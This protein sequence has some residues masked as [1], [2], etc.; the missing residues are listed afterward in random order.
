MVNHGH[1]ARSKAMDL[2][3]PSIAANLAIA[4]AMLMGRTVGG[5]TFCKLGRL[6]F[7]FCFT[8]K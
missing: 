8:T 2:V 4:Y 1:V 6:R 3:I 5:L 7:S